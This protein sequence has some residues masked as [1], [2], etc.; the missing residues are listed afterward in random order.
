VTSLLEQLT[1]GTRL[2]DIAATFGTLTDD[3]LRSLLVGM[4]TDTKA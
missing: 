3:L 1:G 2:S 4:L